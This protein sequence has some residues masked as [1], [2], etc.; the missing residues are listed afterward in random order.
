M[1]STDPTCSRGD[2]AIVRGI[3]ATNDG[4]DSPSWTKGLS[5]SYPATNLLRPNWVIVRVAHVKYDSPRAW[6]AERSPDG[7]DKATSTG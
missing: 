3:D 6:A 7:W 2:A 5:C 4:A 1:A